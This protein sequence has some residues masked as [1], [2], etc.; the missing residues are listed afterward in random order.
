MYDVIVVGAGPAGLTAAIYAC[1]AGKRVLVLEKAAFGGQVTYSPKIENYPG[2]A[3]LSGNELA[4]KMVEQ[5][6]GLG[7]DVELAEALSIKDKDDHKIVVT[8][9][10]D[11][12]GKCVIL[13]TGVKHRMLGIAD[14]ERFIGEGISFC[15]VCDG[16]FYKG[17]EVAVIGGGNSALQEALLLAETSKKV[18]L[19]QN[20]PHFTGEKKLL[21]ALQEKDNVAFITSATV[22]AIL[23]EGDDFKGITVKTEGGTRALP[24]DGIF[25]AIGLVPANAPFAAQAPLNDWGYF[26]AG[27]DCLTPTP[28]VFVAGDCRSKRIRQITTATADGAVAALAACRYL[29]EQ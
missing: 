1:R 5:A 3:Q 24:C 15:A 10:G 14:E 22:E 8:D 20:L 19:V 18:T 17:K 7:A 16:A 11:F 2:F 29:E 6:L 13:A 12:E 27:E 4:D 25:V 26:D 9:S 21:D 23:S 28:G